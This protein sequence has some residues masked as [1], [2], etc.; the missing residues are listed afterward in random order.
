M[1]L[2]AYHDPSRSGAVRLV[3]LSR[4]E[5]AERFIDVSGNVHA[6]LVFFLSWPDWRS[7]IW[8]AAEE[9]G[10]VPDIQQRQQRAVSNPDETYVPIVIPYE[11]TDITF[12]RVIDLRLPDCQEW[13]IRSFGG[14]ELERQFKNDSGWTAF[15]YFHEMLPVLLWAEPGGAMFEGLSQYIGHWMRTHGIEA[16]IFPSARNDSAVVTINGEIKDHKGWN[17][18]DYRNA[19]PPVIDVMLNCTFFNS[20]RSLPEGVRI[21]APS[22]DNRELQGTFAVE[23]LAAW[24]L[25][26]LARS[27]ASGVLDLI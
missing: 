17:L 8:E 22:P 21:K 26:R 23:G 24:H 3:D 27:G 13:F 14:S 18:V 2:L 10:L 19:P 7:P 15:N 4:P 6:F 1:E 16:F 12:A 25:K 9:T 20:P 5:V 11:L